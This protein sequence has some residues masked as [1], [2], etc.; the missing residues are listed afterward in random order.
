VVYSAFLDTIPT[1]VT[2]LSESLDRLESAKICPICVIRVLFLMF[3]F[4]SLDTIPTFVTLL[5]ESLDRLESVLI[6]ENLPNLR[7]LRSIFVLYSAFLDTIP[8]F[9][10]LLSESL[11]RLNLWKSAKSASSAFYFR[12]LFRLSRYNSDIRY[13]AVGITRQAKSVE[14]C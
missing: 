10:A 5:S 11:D 2:L 4:A 14:I 1:F 7:H 9:V 13:S 3:Y 12:G 8:T 6:R